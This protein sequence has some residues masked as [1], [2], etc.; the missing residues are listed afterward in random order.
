MSL[1]GTE[2]N[3]LSQEEMKRLRQLVDNAQ[4]C[5][6]RIKKF[7]EQAKAI[8]EVS[9]I[10]SPWNNATNEFTHVMGW[11]S[12]KPAA[13]LCD[14]EDTRVQIQALAIWQRLQK[15]F[16]ISYKFCSFL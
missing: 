1:E 11:E 12:A 4:E 2:R 8:K 6:P 3:Y 9:T 13:H 5:D 14:S 10:K 7:K 16:E 15:I